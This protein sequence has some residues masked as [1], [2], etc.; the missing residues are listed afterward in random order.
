MKKLLLFLFIIPNLGSAN[1]LDSDFYEPNIANAY[2]GRLLYNFLNEDYPIEKMIK[3]CRPYTG[4]DTAQINLK[5][6]ASNQLRYVNTN[7]AYI[8]QQSKLGL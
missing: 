5:N 4:I 6:K 3:L 7:V 8:G 1:E 2:Q